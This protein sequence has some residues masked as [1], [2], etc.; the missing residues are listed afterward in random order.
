[1]ENS[2]EN[3]RRIWDKEYHWKDHGEEWTGQAKVCGKPYSLW[4]ESV[5]ETFLKANIGPETKVL[6]IGSGHGRWTSEI[7]GLCGHIFVVDLSESCLEYCRSRFADRQNISF[8]QTD[9][10]SLKGI[11]DAAIDFIWSYDVFVHIDAPTIRAYF[12]EFH[13]VLRPKGRAA[14]H[15][16]GRRHYALPFAFL[17]KIQ[18]R[19][20]GIYRWLSMGISS[21]DDGWRSDVSRELIRGAARQS[22]LAVVSQRRSWGPNREFGVPR[23]GDWITILSKP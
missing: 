22:G 6:E 5:V 8:L 10:R 23:Y 9:G 12:E 4:K 17:R 1:M 16:A 14:I 21:D 18:P 15:H 11:G 19:G 13:R 2:I 20:A 7:L 3:N